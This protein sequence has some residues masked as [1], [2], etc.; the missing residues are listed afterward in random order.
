M[1]ALL[2][3]LVFRNEDDIWSPPHTRGRAEQNPSRDSCIAVSSRVRQNIL[4]RNSPCEAIILGKYQTCLNMFRI[5]LMFLR[6]EFLTKI[7]PHTKGY[8][9]GNYLARHFAR[10]FPHVCGGPNREIRLQ[11]P[12]KTG[13]RS[14]IKWNKE[15][16]F[17]RHE[18]CVKGMFPNLGW[19]K[20]F[21]F[22]V[23]RSLIIMGILGI[24]CNSL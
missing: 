13:P 20:F 1:Q 3:S 10:L 6:G 4:V 21:C 14:E 5:F 8:S 15:K 16:V 24:I 11:S 2:P 23:W 9:W 12:R 7:S 19:Q 18:I 22:L 17:I